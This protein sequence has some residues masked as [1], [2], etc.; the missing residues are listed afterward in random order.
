[1]IGVFKRTF[2]L[3][4][5]VQTQINHPNQTFRSS[6][7]HTIHF[8]YTGVWKRLDYAMILMNGHMRLMNYDT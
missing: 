6:Q 5:G 1:M 7:F 8:G 2:K 4:F 3:L